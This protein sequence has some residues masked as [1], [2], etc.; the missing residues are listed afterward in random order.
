MSWISLGDRLD[1]LPL[2]LAG[3]NLCH[4]SSESATVWLALKEPRCVTLKI[5]ATSNNGSIIGTVL[6][7]GE[8]ATIALG[9]HLHLVAVTARSELGNF[10][11]FGQLYAYDL[12]FSISEPTLQSALT[13]ADFPLIPISY[14]P[15]QLPTFS[16]PPQDLNRLR[17][18]H[19]S[20][21]KPHGKGYD[22]LPI[23]DSAIEQGAAFPDDRP[24]QL[25]LT[26]DR[27]YGDDVAD[28]LLWALTDAGNCLLGWQEVLPL[29][30]P[31]TPN[32]LPP[33]QRSQ[34]A[35]QQAGLTAGLQDKPERAKSHLFGLGEYY[36]IYLFSMS[37]V[38]W[39][40]P[41]P[42]GGEIC[43]NRQAAKQWDRELKQ[44]KP[45]AHT[46]WKA[47][48]ASANIPTYTIFDDHDVSDD[49]YLNQAWCLGVLGKPLGRRVVQNALLAYA[50]FQAWGNMPLQFQDG[51]AGA[52]LLAAARDWS[53]SAG[54]DKKADNLFSLQAID[55]IQRWHLKQGKVF[56][57]DVGDSWNMNRVA[58]AELL[59]TL[60]DER[61]RT[62]V[63]SGD[64]HYS[65]A[66]RLDS[67]SLSPAEATI[68]EPQWRSHL[69]IQFTASAIKN[70]EFKTRLVHT[71]I[72]SLLWPERQRFWLGWTNPPKM[73][74]IKG[75]KRLDNSSPD[76]ESR[77]EWIHRQ[78]AQFPAWGKKLSWLRLPQ[79]P[80]D[81]LLNLVKWLWQN[82]WLQEG[83]EAIGLN[84][85]GFIEFIW[86][87]KADEQVAIQD[88]YWYS[89]WGKPRIA[90]SRFVAQL[91]LRP[92]HKL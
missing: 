38:F 87:E 22:A 90:V 39:A 62:I 13:S 73:V 80:S 65:A 19:G 4:T 56:H 18:V 1:G 42:T 77:L 64:I 83:Q 37:Q 9:K 36:A 5:Y 35:E 34:I 46:L 25:F 10:L 52:Q 89:S 92:P 30:P 66:L 12:S 75:Q 21:R 57:T 3:P 70:S 2:I 48:R 49:W 41:F 55:W 50:V 69:L 60:F 16:L 33:G 76:W 61:D 67:W 24:Q 23:L 59:T 43:Q 84:N 72:K 78:P 8:R 82:R 74:E 63:L 51:Q 26:G 20:C 6:M 11:H 7:A 32:Q 58:L 14:F 91:Q 31:I 88:I 17:I 44:L 79:K 53:A 40:Q 15:H 86:S 68:A 54:K 27:I 28:P 47:R 29:L 71:K 81:R 45:F 85:L